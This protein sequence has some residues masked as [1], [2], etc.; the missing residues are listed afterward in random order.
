VL[1][2][3]IRVH[4]KARR[5][6]DGVRSD[7]NSGIWIGMLTFCCDATDEVEFADSAVEEVSLTFCDIYPF[8]SLRSTD[9]LC[10]I[11]TE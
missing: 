3:S 8:N 7:D 4:K 11:I 2:P 10:K 5:P 1:S 9:I 6:A